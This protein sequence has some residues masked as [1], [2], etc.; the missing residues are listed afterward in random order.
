MALINEEMIHEVDSFDI[1][2]TFV[3]RSIW[4]EL[5]TYHAHQMQY[6][7]FTILYRDNPLWD[8]KKTPAYNPPKADDFL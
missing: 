2:T 1:P 3:T 7:D 4:D 6:T 8:V 5:N